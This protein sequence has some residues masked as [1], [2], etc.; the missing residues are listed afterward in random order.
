MNKEKKILLIL[1][2]WYYPGYKAG[3]PVQSVY[4]L[5]VFLSRWMEVKIV[6]RI[7]D[8]NAQDPY[9]GIEPNKW[10]EI[11]ENHS[12]IYL[13]I[14]GIKKGLIKSIIKENRGNYILINGL[15]SFYFSIMPAF[16]TMY[17]G[18][19]KT[20]IAVRGMLHRSALSVK[21]T[22]K[23]VFLAFARGFGLFKRVTMLASSHEELNEIE[24]SMGKVKIKLA[25]NIP[26]SVKRLKETKISDSSIFKVV[27]LGRISKE[28]NPIALLKAM[29]SFESKCKLVFAG[30]P[31]SNDYMLNFSAEAG[32]LP[33]NIEFEYIS[34]LP[35]T[36]VP[37]L[38]ESADIMALPSLGENFGHAIFESFVHS[39]PVV[40]GNNTQWSKVEELKAGKIVD[41]NSPE[42]IKSAIQAFASMN[43]EEIKIWRAG[44]N[45]MAV[46][47]FETNNFKDLYLNLFS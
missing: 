40:I 18:V 8:L 23:Y 14:V 43:S 41:P 24:L 5:A 13:D 16:Y 33:S 20:F 10:N 26:M 7:K 25:P 27:F 38:L 47:Y 3:G 9:P 17:F 42:E 15:F 34:D 37:K 31:G 22:K 30:A 6:T 1:T 21:P 39:V 2:D 36:E 45:Q 11:G 35:H 12:V 4:N 29:Q 19:S 44:A 28:K 32:K 46:N